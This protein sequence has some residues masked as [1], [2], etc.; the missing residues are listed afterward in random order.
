MG[1]FSKYSRSIMAFSIALI[2]VS[3]VACNDSNNGNNNGP[4][5]TAALTVMATGPAAEAV[6]VATNTLVTATFSEA[7][8]AATLDSSSFT[9]GVT[10]GLPMTGS[11]SL[12]A[13]TNT[14]TFKTAGGGFSDSTAYTAVITTAV[15]SAGGKSLAGNYEWSF[16]T[17]VSVDSTPP[18]VI[19]TDPEDTATDVAINRNISADFSEAM[20]AASINSSTFSITDGSSPVIG[21]VELTGS[22]AV[23]TPENNL[24]TSTLY[25]ATLNTDVTDLAAVALAADEVWTFTTGD[26]VAQGPEPVNLRTAGDFVI[27]T[28]TGITNV[29]VSAITGDIGSSPITAAAMD[30]VSCTEITGTIYGSDAAYSGSGDVTCFAGAAPDNTLVAN[31]VLDMGTAYADA[32]GR[33]TPDY[34]ELHAGDVSGK[35]LVPGLY[36]WGTN[37]LINTDVTLSGGANDVWI[38]QVAGDVLQ[39]SNTQVSL[40]GGALAKNVFWQVGGGTGVVIDTGATFN[41]VVL[42][43]KAV[44]VKTGATVNGRLLSQTA[45]TLQGNT[46]TQPE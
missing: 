7:I 20:N 1:I 4:G 22:T 15:E 19:S 31:A 27:L 33:T 39:A 6:G 11:V 2:S 26:A 12:D 30:N 3:L 9:V 37:V 24:A 14:G 45:V 35:T 38:F 36:K 8:S 29:P 18:V 41:G 17:G 42:A 16:T 32:S 46:V 25:T 21:T 5:T 34:T 13:D 40:T 43:E 28:K 10:G 44:S 23:F